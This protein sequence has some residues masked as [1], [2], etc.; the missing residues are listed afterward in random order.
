MRSMMPRLEQ[1]Y[2]S[3]SCSADNLRGVCPTTLHS[4]AAYSSANTMS[5]MILIAVN[6]VQNRASNSGTEVSVIAVTSRTITSVM[7]RMKREPTK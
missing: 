7:S 3:R 6:K 1:T 5:A 4:R 2:S